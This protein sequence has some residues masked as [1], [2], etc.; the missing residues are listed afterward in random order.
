MQNISGDNRNARDDWNANARFWDDHMG[1][2]N[3]FFNVLVWPTVERLLSM[4]AGERISGKEK[5]TSLHQRGSQAANFAQNLFEIGGIHFMRIIAC[6]YPTAPCQLMG[7][8]KQRP[9]F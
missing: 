2:G 1:D 4:K 3:D 7:T 9:Y 5:R 8:R 6:G